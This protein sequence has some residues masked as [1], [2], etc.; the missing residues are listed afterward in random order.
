MTST[1]IRMRGPNIA[2][3][4]RFTLPTKAGPRTYEA[5]VIGFRRNGRKGLAGWIETRDDDGVHRSVQPARCEVVL[6]P[7]QRRAAMLAAIGAEFDATNLA[8]LANGPIMDPLRLFLP[9][10]KCS[11]EEEARREMVERG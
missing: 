1:H 11:E 7:P 10:G 6:T 9:A 8:A 2:D 5:S 3:R 4:V